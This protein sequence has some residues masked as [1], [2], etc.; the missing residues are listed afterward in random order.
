[1]LLD[2]PSEIL[3]SI[4]RYFDVDDPAIDNISNSCK[5]LH[6]LLDKSIEDHLDK[7][8][9]RKLSIF[10]DQDKSTDPFRALRKILSRPRLAFHFTHLRIDPLETYSIVKREDP[11]TG[12]LTDFGELSERDNVKCFYHALRH[13][14]FR[15]QYIADLSEEALFEGVKRAYK[16]WWNIAEHTET[17]S[18]AAALT[19]RVWVASIVLLLIT[20]PG[21]QSMRVS[22]KCH[23][24][25]FNNIVI[26]LGQLSR[27]SPKSRYRPLGNLSMFHSTLVDW[28]DHPLIGIKPLISLIP[29]A[30][31]PTMLVLSATVFEEE[32][33]YYLWPNDFQASMVTILNLNFCR[34][35]IGTLAIFLGRFSSLRSF[36]CCFVVRDRGKKVTQSLSSVRLALLKAATATLECLTIDTHDDRLDGRFDYI[37]PLCGFEVLRTISLDVELLVHDGKFLPPADML[38]SS[39]EV[40]RVG[41]NST[42][43]QFH[44][45]PELH[46]DDFPALREVTTY[47]RIIDN[48]YAPQFVTNE[49]ARTR[50]AAERCETCHTVAGE[51]RMLSCIDG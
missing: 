8:F 17:Y 28:R 4:L 39:V 14:I 29:F 20:L 35:S 46:S 41:V 12:R 36:R 21:L 48:V 5:F 22:A 51:W 13:L 6:S 42:S 11:W 16:A 7:K 43:Q 18:I 2:L 3:N 37:G 1:M 47:H 24:R 19:H 44:N 30:M 32:S 34:L 33:V 15:S 27:D 45:F 25:T 49:G 23:D 9:S 31:L 38:P 10:G 26:Q 50:L 40:L